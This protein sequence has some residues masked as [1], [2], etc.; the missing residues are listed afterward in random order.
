VASEDELTCS[1]RKYHIAKNPGNK[2]FGIS[3]V[4]KKKGRG[5]NQNRKKRLLILD[6]IL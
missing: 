3:M 4:R 5:K 6:R 1:H 2:I